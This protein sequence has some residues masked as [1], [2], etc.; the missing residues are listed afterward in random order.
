M[1]GV[2]FPT[3]AL[4]EAWWDPQQQTLF[5]TP[6]PLNEHTSGQPTTFRVVNLPDP[7]SWW[8]ELEDGGAVEAAPAAD[9]LEVHTT[10]APRRHRIKPASRA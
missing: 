3:V 4:S 8:V 5:V 10:S 9:T 6:E 1:I 2:D 7:T